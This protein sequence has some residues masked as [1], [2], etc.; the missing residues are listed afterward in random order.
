MV[1]KV[2]IVFVALLSLAMVT[3]AFMTSWVIA[4]QQPPQNEPKD[5]PKVQ[6][7]EPVAKD[8]LKEFEEAH[9]VLYAVKFARA[10][11][12]EM[13]KL[14]IERFQTA[15]DVVN[16]RFTVYLV[17]SGGG[18]YSPLVYLLD[19][20][21]QLVA[22]RLELVEKPE[23]EIAV[24]EDWVKATKE[25]EKITKAN[26]DAGKTDVTQGFKSHYDRLDA[27]IQLLKAKRKLKK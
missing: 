6:S 11:D 14:L 4:A 19:A 26:L 3:F 27:E 1:S 17:G 13:R 16:A 21:H 23:E 8:P 18:G 12:D 24:L 10:N 22:S 5:N 15:R 9:P 25:F 7:Q 2:S 20:L